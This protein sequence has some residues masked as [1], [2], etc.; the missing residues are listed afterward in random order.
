MLNMLKTDARAHSSRICMHVCSYTYVHI[1]MYIFSIQVT[2]THHAAIQSIP[3][4]LSVVQSVSDQER[5]I[6]VVDVNYKR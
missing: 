4:L 6:Q 3:I 2:V 5:R 1:C